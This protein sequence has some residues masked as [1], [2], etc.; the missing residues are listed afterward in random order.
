ML[1][2]EIR[3]AMQ[4]SEGKAE[5]NVSAVI[6]SGEFLCVFGPSGA[7]K[8]T[9]LRILAGLVKPDF[10]RIVFGNTVWFD[11]E[12]QINLTPQERSV[13]LMFQDYAL[14]PNMTVE[15]NIQFAQ[16][17]KDLNSVKNIME[18]FGLTSLCKRKPH[19]L[20]GG[21]KQRV[22]L[23]RALASNPG[24]LMLDEP[25]SAIDRDMRLVLQ[26]EIQKAHLLL[27][28]VSLMVSHDAQEILHLATSVLV[29]KNGK[30]IAKDRPDVLFRHSDEM[31]QLLHSPDLDNLS[32]H[33]S[34]KPT[35]YDF[36]PTFK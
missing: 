34:E 17:Q 22:A 1:E 30:M 8:T 19:Q 28:P 25:L 27:K 24:L 2:F 31:N 36:I 32:S 33:S 35:F 26:D 9:L 3:H 4:T 23:A 14:F 16:K 12:K 10:G 29:I 7:G 18:L 6:N 11:S 20:S 21:Q 13:G 15:R 5:L